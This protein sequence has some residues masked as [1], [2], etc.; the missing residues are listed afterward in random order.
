MENFNDTTGNR[1][2]DL[3]ACSAVRQPTALPSP[4]YRRTTKIPKG[5]NFREVDEFN[6]TSY[7]LPLFESNSKPQLPEVPR[8][9]EKKSRL[10]S[11]EYNLFS[12]CEYF[13]R[14]L[15]FRIFLCDTCLCCGSTQFLPQNRTSVP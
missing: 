14:A 9:T 5:L 13:S 1:N 2:R 11:D 12:N 4:R 8:S 7:Y 3:P 15:F 6:L 10:D